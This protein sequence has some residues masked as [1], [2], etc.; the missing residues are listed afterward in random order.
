[1]RKL[2]CASVAVTVLLIGASL[3]SASDIIGKA[4][5]IPGGDTFYVCEPGLCTKMCDGRSRSHPA[6]RGRP[7]KL[8][9]VVDPPVERE[10]A[11][12]VV[13]VPQCPS[14]AEIADGVVVSFAD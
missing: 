12:S 2:M 14:D 10:K 1:M 8:V 4:D 3:C 13:R 11:P 6:K 5:R 7:K 9:T